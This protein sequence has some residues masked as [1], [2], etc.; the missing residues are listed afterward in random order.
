M[1]FRKSIA[2]QFLQHTQLWH[3]GHWQV[4]L[5]LAQ[6]WGRAMAVILQGADVQNDKEQIL[7]LLSLGDTG[8]NIN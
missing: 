1:V 3:W 6:L 7:K 4:H 2:T 5:C 8:G